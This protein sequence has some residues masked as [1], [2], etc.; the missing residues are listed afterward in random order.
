M[1]GAAGA[2]G[3]RIIH[4]HFSEKTVFAEKKCLRPTDSRRSEWLPN[5]AHRIK[6]K[7]AAGNMGRDQASAPKVKAQR[8]VFCLCRSLNL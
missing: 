8:L 7:R 1:S 5:E 6:T 4:R 2:G 3:A